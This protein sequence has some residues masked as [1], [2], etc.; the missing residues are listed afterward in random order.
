MEETELSLNA[1]TFHTNLWRLVNDSDVDGIVW[2]HQ[3]DGIV[4]N[5][6]LI[7]KVLPLKCFQ[8]SSLLRFAQQLQ[9][10]GFEKSESVKDDEPNIHHYFHPDFKRN[11]HELCR[12]R[13]NQ[14]FRHSVKDDRKNDLTERWRDHCD[15]GESFSHPY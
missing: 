5:T 10:Y 2:N 12:L 14:N 11:Q 9:F 6:N 13:C 1:N 7:E 4:V 15:H 8:A 3:G